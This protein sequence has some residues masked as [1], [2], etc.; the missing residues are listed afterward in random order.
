MYL[1][2]PHIIT[3]RIRDTNQI[4]T[5]EWT[6]VY[7]YAFQ[8]IGKARNA[9]KLMARSK[10]GVLQFTLDTVMDGLK[11]R[12]IGE[13]PGEESPFNFMAEVKW[14]K[15]IKLALTF[16]WK[17]SRYEAQFYGEDG[18]KIEHGYIDVK[19]GV[20]IPGARRLFVPCR[21]RGMANEKVIY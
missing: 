10:G 2:R 3:L 13:K 20:T 15:N 8:V 6:F 1:L 14:G 19:M 16:N 4:K 5:T 7:G 17:E 18:S 9:I 11:R 21:Y 12:G